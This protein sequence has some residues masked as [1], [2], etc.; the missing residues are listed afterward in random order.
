MDSTTATSISLSWSVPSGTVV[1]S[2]EVMWQLS[3]SDVISIV[4]LSGSTTSYTMEG[5]ENSGLYNISVT[6]ENDFGSVTSNPLM[7]STLA[8]G[9]SI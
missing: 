4:T 3:G 8:A 9:N 5:L 7:V 6:A 2:Y 1:D